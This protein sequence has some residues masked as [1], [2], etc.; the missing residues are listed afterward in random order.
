MRIE[1]SAGAII[2]SLK[3]KQFLLVKHRDGHWEFPKGKQEAGET[4]TQTLLREVK[5][6]T[7]MSGRLLPFRT[8]STYYYYHKGKIKKTVEYGVLLS[9]D[10]PV[11]SSE[12]LD[13]CW[14]PLEKVRSLLKFSEHKRVFSEC[15]KEMQRLE[16]L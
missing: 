4:L 3:R 11:I 13:F 1:V 12:H 8:H 6:E 15:V 14:K 5:E 7:G 16:L 2:Y 10:D 9:D